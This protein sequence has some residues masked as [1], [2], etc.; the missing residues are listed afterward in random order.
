M[1]TRNY[2]GLLYRVRGPALLP[3]D[4]RGRRGGHDRLLQL[5]G[6]EVVEGL[7]REHAVA[8]LLDGH[9]AFFGL[10]ALTARA[11]EAPLPRLAAILRLGTLVAEALGKAV[12]HQLAQA[13]AQRDEQTRPWVCATVASRFDVDELMENVL[14]NSALRH[15]NTQ[16][17]VHSTMEAEQIKLAL[18]ALAE[19]L[20]PNPASETFRIR[21][22]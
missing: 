1:T 15:S 2:T 11:F 9:D 10:E 19:P 6:N 13:F 14:V 4:E 16:E 12:F 7:E 3:G 20:R 22:R 18:E 21:F 5:R 17:L 8:L